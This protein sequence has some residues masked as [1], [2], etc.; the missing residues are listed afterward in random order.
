MATYKEINGVK[1]VT[2]TSDPTASESVGTVWYNSTSP[3]ALKYTIESAGAWS[4]GGA[5]NQGRYRGGGGGIGTLTEGMVTGGYSTTLPGY[6]VATEQYDGSTW[7]E[8]PMANYPTATGDCGQCG[9]VTASLVAGGNATSPVDSVFEGNGSTWSAGGAFP[10]AKIRIG[11][12]GSQ[13]A[14]LSVTGTPP[15]TYT[16]CFHYNGT[17]WTAGGAYVQGGYNIGVGG[18]ETAAI[19]AD[20]YG[21]PGGDSSDAATYNGTTWTEITSTTNARGE[22]SFSTKGTPTSFIATGNTPG[23]TEK[24]DGSSWTE[25]ADMG[26]GRS[27]SFSGGTAGAL[28]VAGGN[29]GGV[30]TTENWEDPVYTIKTVTVS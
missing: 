11:L 3:A 2:K 30:T 20:G 25:I 17:A 7:T 21:P 9:D 23:A 13:T 8:G 15:T 22:F 18:T 19:A 28:F 26:T 27:S 4:S 5:L 12:A 24:W 1:V 29:P 14:T 16:N 6:I 10:S